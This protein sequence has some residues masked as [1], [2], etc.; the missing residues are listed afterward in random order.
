MK[1]ILM[2]GFSGIL[3][4]GQVEG[5]EMIKGKITDGKKVDQIRVDLEVNQ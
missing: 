5:Q 4:T 1:Q 2:D 3:D